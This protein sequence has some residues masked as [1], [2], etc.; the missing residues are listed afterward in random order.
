MTGARAMA[1]AGDGAACV[2]R[3]DGEGPAQE[4]RTSNAAGAAEPHPVQRWRAGEPTAGTARLAHE[5]PVAFEYNGISHAVMLATPADL[6]DFAVGFSFSEGIAGPGQCY[7]VDV[8]ATVDGLTL[9][10]D[11]AAEAFAQLK[12]RRRTLAGRTGC[13]ICG[14]ESLQQ[15]LRPLPDLARRG[16]RVGAGALARA[17]AGLAA[18]QPLQQATGA[19]HL[20]VWC[21][22]QGEIVLGR[23][24]VGRHNALDKLVGALLR[25]RI[26]RSGG[27]AMV[28]SRASVEMVQKSAAAGIALLAAVSAPTALAVRVAQ[29]CGQ[30]LVGFAH[31][32]S[33]NVYTH[34]DRIVG[35]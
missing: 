2:A 27:F 28:T 14:A 10:I 22:A 1:V 11:I 29:G 13:G 25:E 16:P 12:S 24:D 18:R 3:R 19:A 31:A 20:A 23:E 8:R 26:D 30:T 6:H 9:A 32:A 5:V 34:A 15:V 4:L 7:G 17:H 33:F 35:G 21:D